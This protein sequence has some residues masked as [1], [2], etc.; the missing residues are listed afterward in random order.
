[1][2]QTITPTDKIADVLKAHPELKD[3]LI[4][5]SSRYKRLNNP[6]I[7]NTVAK[8][9]TIEM[10]A[11]VAGENLEE[12]LDF[13]NNNIKQE[14][15]YPAQKVAS[16]NEKVANQQPDTPPE[17]EYHTLDARELTGFFLPEI[18]AKAKNVPPGMG[19]KI[20]QNF[21]PAP[22]Y[23]VMSDMGWDHVTW[24]VSDEE[25][26]IFFYR[27]QTEPL[28]QTTKDSVASVPSKATARV[29]I[30]LQSATPVVYPVI[31]RMM[32][33]ETLMERVEITELQVWE[34]TEK[35]LGWL[36]KGKADISFS[37][38]MA[39]AKMLGKKDSGLKFASV[40]VWDNFHLLTR[41]PRASSF[42]DL[43]G[44]TIH[45]PLVKNS[46][47]SRVTEY[48]MRAVGEDPANFKFVFG[49]SG[50]PFGRPKE[51]ASKLVTGE[52]ET[53][54]LREPEASYALEGSAELHEAVDYSEIWS[55]LHPESR[56]LP[57]AGVV[58]K[59]DFVRQ[60]PEIAQLFLAE[61]EKAI[62]WVSE[63]PDEAAELSYEAMGRTREEVRRFLGR[64]RFDH[65]R[66]CDVQEEIQDY[67]NMIDPRRKLT[68][69]PEACELGF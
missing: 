66:A 28:P 41:I 14:Q 29:P 68:I 25:F 45:M 69:P 34:E 33:S 21:E 53:A 42:A 57:N 39:I 64:V 61:L 65:V 8:V 38:V 30:V 18:I 51:I 49:K 16:E 55:K 32:E 24:K 17:I 36:L 56:G 60:H 47:P 46:P 26:H 37:A 44:Q 3:K 6:A 23:N 4:Q 5:R 15:A 62:A 9:A 2:A 35:H 48:L 59:E 19:L 27:R 20:I 7:F 54:L 11:R 43:R 13:L 10:V 58:F 22:L 40:D 50:D 63:H 1:M 52:I 31:L 12:L 67:L